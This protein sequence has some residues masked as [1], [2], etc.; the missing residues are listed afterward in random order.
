MAKISNIVQTSPQPKSQ[1]E[2]DATPQAKMFESID[3]II[4]QDDINAWL[5]TLAQPI[6][7]DIKYTIGDYDHQSAMLAN[8]VINYTC[9]V[10]YTI[11]TPE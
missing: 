1:R 5:A 7:D 9:L 2:W 4:L 3:P 8:N 11:W 6:T 10:S